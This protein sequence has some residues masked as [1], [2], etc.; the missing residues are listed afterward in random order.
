MDMVEDEIESQRC[1]LR[2][3]KKIVENFERALE[4]NKDMKDLYLKNDKP[5]IEMG[6][7]GLYEMKTT[8]SETVLEF[9]RSMLVMHYQESE[10]VNFVYS[11]KNRN[12]IAKFCV[13]EKKFFVYKTKNLDTEKDVI[14]ELSGIGKSLKFS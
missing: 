8:L 13:K 10:H 14:A 5:S 1:P 6:Y 12:W 4:E 3:S 11:G 7:E 2:F 9:A